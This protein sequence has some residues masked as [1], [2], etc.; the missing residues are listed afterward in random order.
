MPGLKFQLIVT[1]LQEL[2]QFGF[3]SDNNIVWS[4]HWR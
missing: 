2:V 3:N 1:H 4:L